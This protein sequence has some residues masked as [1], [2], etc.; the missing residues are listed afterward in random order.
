MI[1][2]DRS[3]LWS[4]TYQSKILPWAQ[5]SLHAHFCP[6]ESCWGVPSPNPACR[7]H[8]LHIPR[9]AASGNTKALQAEVQQL[10]SE[11]NARYKDY[12]EKQRRVKELETV[13]SNQEN[14]LGHKKEKR[15]ELIPS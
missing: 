14:I 6:T 15:H 13:K 4:T 5:I 12:R 11:Q 1:L 8:K 10:T 7:R 2:H 3:P 9:F